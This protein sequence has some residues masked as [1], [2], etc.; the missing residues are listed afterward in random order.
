MAMRGRKLVFVQL[1]QLIRRRTLIGSGLQVAPSTFI[2][3]K[4]YKEGL[5]GIF[6][7]K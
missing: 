4:P 5:K 2:I 6:L 1:M 3:Q 7:K